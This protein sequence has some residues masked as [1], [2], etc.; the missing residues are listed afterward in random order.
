MGNI[1]IEKIRKVEQGP[2]SGKLLFSNYDNYRKLVDFIENSKNLK[3]GY[4][5][6]F[7]DEKKE[8]FKDV[9]LQS[10]SKSQIL[11]NGLISEDIIFDNLGL[12]YE[13]INKI[14]TIESRTDEI[15]WDFKWDSKFVS[16]NTR[17][18]ECV[19]TGH[20][21]APVEIELN[22]P[23]SNPN[24]S[25]YVEGQLYQELKFKIQLKKYEKLLYG[26]KEGNFYIEKQNTDGTKE[27]LFNLDILQDFDKIDEVIRLP[28]NR[29]CELK[30][31]AENEVPYAKITLF[32]YYKSI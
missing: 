15:K 13:E 32:V 27:N 18:L 23:V 4:K 26:T 7:K 10:I 11:T 22:G 19:N 31:N 8:Y 5:I 6:P 29:S 3:F 24:I 1:F 17:S 2:I 12:W 21:E 25:L 20:V 9:N 16:Y 28:K 14:Y 30:I